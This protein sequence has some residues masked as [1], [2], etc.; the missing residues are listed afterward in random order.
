M[1]HRPMS[2]GPLVPPPVAIIRVAATLHIIRVKWVVDVRTKPA[3]EFK[4]VP[5]MLG[6]LQHT[7]N[8]RWQRS[9]ALKLSCGL[10][11]QTV[12]R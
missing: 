4:V 1:S 9:S 12:S 2:V 11:Q 7:A 5:P 6:E 3:D 8:R 10:V